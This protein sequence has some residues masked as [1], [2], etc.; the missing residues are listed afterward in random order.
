V[1]TR[2]RRLRWVNP[3]TPVMTLGVIAV[4]LVFDRPFLA[5]YG[6]GLGQLAL[7]GVGAIFAGGFAGLARLGREER[8][9]RLLS[10]GPAELQGGGQP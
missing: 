6:T 3:T 8:G 4:L 10:T 5:P 1:A 2:V 9:E 7:L